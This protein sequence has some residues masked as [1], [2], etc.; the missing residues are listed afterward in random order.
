MPDQQHTGIN[1]LLQLLKRHHDL[2]LHH[3]IQRRGRLVR[4]DHLRAQR[5]S[6]RQ[7]DALF[8]AATQ[9]MRVHIRHTAIQTH[10]LKQFNYAL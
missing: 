1:L 4:Q 2:T 6:D 3:H 5:R 9:L 7:C 8:H 10:A